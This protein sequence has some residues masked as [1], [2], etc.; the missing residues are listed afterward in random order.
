MLYE[1]TRLPFSFFFFLEEKFVI[2]ITVMD[3]TDVH[4]NMHSPF[5]ERIN[6]PFSRSHRSITACLYIH[7]G[8]V[9]YMRIA[10]FIFT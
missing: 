5:T 4:A 6:Y 1:I 2:S 9:R 8:S 7:S 10:K 3:I